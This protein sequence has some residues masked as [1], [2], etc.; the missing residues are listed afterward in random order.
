M[1][2]RAAGP[3]RLLF[4]RRA[5]RAAWIVTSS[6]GGGLVDGDHV[7]LDVAIERGAT[8][9][10][11]TQASS[12]VY[13]GIS[14]QHTTV[15]AQEDS[16]ALVLP[17]PVV[18]FANAH[19]EQRTEIT[20]HETASLALLD[21]ITA[22]RVAFGERWSSALVDTTLK[23]QVG[24]RVTLHDRL[25]LDRESGSIVGKMGRFEALATVLLIGPAFEAAATVLVRDKVKAPLQRGDVDMV[26]AASPLEG[27]VIVRLAATTVAAATQL[28]RALLTDALGVTGEEP[29]RRKW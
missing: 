19:F 10:L 3:Q 28:G 12:K 21:T 8:A 2:G 1:R 27:G 17:D 4:P 14:R 9:L 6:F 23:V 29:W 5:G 24:A 20:L 25:R 13:K 11:T 15:V 7:A 18:P 16:I 22:G 26:V